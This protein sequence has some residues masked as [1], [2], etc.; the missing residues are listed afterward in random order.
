[1][2]EISEFEPD[3]SVEILKHKLLMV[4]RNSKILKNV[5]KTSDFFKKILRKKKFKKVYYYIYLQLAKIS[6]KNNENYL[7][8]ALANSGNDRDRLESLIK[9]HE[10]HR[11][12]GDIKREILYLEN[13]AELRK[14]YKDND[15]LK[16]LFI[17]L[18][19]YHLHE[20]NFLRS[21]QFFFEA[22]KYSEKMEA[23]SSGYI[24]NRIAKA[25]FHLGKNK[26]A[27]KFLGRSLNYAEKFRNEHLKMW[28]FNI[29]TEVFM[30]EANYNKAEQ[31]NRRSIA[32]GEKKNFPELILNAYFMRSKLFFYND[33]D[34][35]GLTILKNTADFGINN[36]SYE[37]LMPVLY[38]FI[39]RAIHYNNPEEAM[40]Y[41]NKMSK[42]Y[43]PFYRGY[44]FYY[45]LRGMLNEKIG[46]PE[47]AGEYYEKTFR[48]LNYFFSELNHLRH[49]PYREEITFI[50]S[51]I[52]RFNFR[53]FD[54]TNEL[55]YLRMA[56]YS[57]EVKNPYMFRRISDGDRRIQSIEKEKTRVE[58]E[59]RAAE[60]KILKGH[61]K[62]SRIISY[63]KMVDSLKTELIELEDLILEFPK[64]YK[65]FLISE[66][67]LTKIRNI[68]DRDTLVV[69]F[70]VLE[71]NTYAF[72]IDHKSAGYK[73]LEKGS[74]YIKNL[75]G[76]LLS[77][78]Q[79]Y[80]NNEV[81]FLRIK[82]DQE[83][84]AELYN[85]LLHD[86]LEFHKDKEKLIII[87]DDALFKIPFE[88]L[89]TKKKRSY[90]IKNVIFS[91]YENT[92]FLIDRYSIEYLFSI[93]HLKNNK[94]KGRK[95]YDISAF[96]F[97]VIDPK[98]KW[99]SDFSE[100]G[101]SI[102][103]L[104]PS[105]KEE[106]RKIKNIWGDKRGR[107]Y[108]GKEFTKENFNK[109]ATVSRIIHLATH[110]VSNRKYP[111]YSMFLFSARKENDPL[112]FVSDI[113][114]LRLNCDL[115]FLSTCGSLENHL[116]G[117]Q[118][119]SGITATLYNSGAE[120]MIAS[121]WPVNEFSSE[122]IVPFYTE[123]KNE[124]GR[125]DDL[126]TILRNVKISFR[127][128]II[129]LGNGRKLSFSHPMIWANFN[130][131]KFFIKK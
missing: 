127:K 66:L 37:H 44:F 11:R 79:R 118:L 19:D 40:A 93:F 45:F 109:T 87:P 116:M 9:L 102:F 92:Q 123:L 111:W 41:L 42:I 26:L 57:G 74:K 71:D 21:L 43:T 62:E 70:I 28:I 51:R 63:K 114:R 68:L 82:Y 80:E 84:S 97:P 39:K 108:T 69:R 83:K 29:Y 18:G 54:K 89:I 86:V 122:I 22:I 32:I 5:Q 76:S 75:I 64:R 131:Y 128:R 1:M 77:P 90:R 100:K 47:V 99:L 125:A 27:L 129:E 36:E 106:I 130:L 60:E 104:L 49:Y 110:F 23:S 4:G 35:S 115:I 2:V 8:K 34:I 13:Q 38:E 6:D 112:Y 65:R 46:K 14:K 98:N 88:A 81:D 73:K 107:F 101:N 117:E 50:Y 17:T 124:K 48:S 119:I 12:N 94:K 7:K 113:S 16:Q 96:G 53:M 30:S 61:I 52:A 78:I 10:F 105:S 85:I 55:K 56:F 91:E 120:S 67:D 31:Y 59:V 103:T 121:L 25:F 95:K 33:Q 58:N 3:Q 72:V 126:A 15:S 24:Y 20:N